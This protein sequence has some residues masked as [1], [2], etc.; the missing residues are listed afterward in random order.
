MPSS[1]SVRG[2]LEEITGIY[3]KLTALYMGQGEDI[4][5][6][7][8]S[9]SESGGDASLFIT[10]MGGNTF[11]FLEQFRPKLKPYLDLFSRYKQFSEELIA[12]VA[13]ELEV[14][15]EQ[16]FSIDSRLDFFPGAR[17]T[18]KEDPRL[19]GHL[20]WDYVPRYNLVDG[21]L[22]DIEY[23]GREGE[24][25]IPVWFGPKFQENGAHT[26]DRRGYYQREIMLE[27]REGYLSLR[28]PEDLVRLV[29][30]MRLQTEAYG[31]PEKLG[32]VLESLINKYNIR[33]DLFNHRDD[34]RDEDSDEPLIRMGIKH[35]PLSHD[36][37]M[38]LIH[39]GFSRDEVKLI[40]DRFFPKNHWVQTVLGHF[41]VH[42]HLVYGFSKT[43]E[44]S[45]SIRLTMEYLARGL[46]I[47]ER[48]YSMHVYDLQSGTH[49]LSGLVNMEG[50]LCIDPNGAGAGIKLMLD[51]VYGKGSVNASSQT[52]YLERKLLPPEERVWPGRV[53]IAE[54]FPYG[55]ELVF[56]AVTDELNVAYLALEYIASHFSTELDKAR[57][58]TFIS[59][60]LRIGV[61]RKE[62]VGLAVRGDN[63]AKLL[64]VE[65]EEYTS[66]EHIRRPLSGAS[67]ELAGLLGDSRLAGQFRNLERLLSKGRSGALAIESEKAAQEPIQYRDK[68]EGKSRFY[69]DLTDVPRLRKF[70]FFK[71]PEFFEGFVE[72]LNGRNA[73]K[74][75]GI[76]ERVALPGESAVKSLLE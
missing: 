32:K 38:E 73:Q 44:N 5:T 55:S 41:L 54:I 29:E 67:S 22:E 76:L 2:R 75:I 28:E 47:Q 49:D 66:K 26:T 31:K 61:R 52:A 23:M 42:H 24:Q 19:K 45:S 74:R 27:N 15:E 53:E 36:V 56:N 68:Y 39:L 48:A 71:S 43:A 21:E 35:T 18:V 59:N 3:G 11:E 63:Y 30:L 17:V 9:V 8:G 62:P 50:L 69:M 20:S 60:D 72:Y 70:D 64:C 57:S 25:N 33:L 1:D 4:A 12:D 7:V 37:P 51:Q 10:M 34:P 13:S 40:Y 14:S 46:S 6:M 58:Q 16:L 65:P